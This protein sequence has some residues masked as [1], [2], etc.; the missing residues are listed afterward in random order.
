MISSRYRRSQAQAD[1]FS[2]VTAGAGKN[3]LVFIKKVELT[4]VNI[5]VPGQSFKAT[6]K[7]LIQP[8]VRVERD[9]GSRWMYER[10]MVSHGIAGRLVATMKAG[11]GTSA[12]TPSWA[13]VIQDVLVAPATSMPSAM[14][15]SASSW[16]SGSAPETP[17][18][19]DEYP[20][21][22]KAVYGQSDLLR[23]R[24][25]VGLVKDQLVGE[26]E[27]AAACR[28]SSWRR[29]AA[30]AAGQARLGHEGLPGLARFTA[31]PAVSGCRQDGAARWQMIAAYRT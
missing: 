9:T 1:R 3:S 26:I 2:G 5:D 6:K 21:L 19:P 17:V 24:N 29:G 13:V 31:R 30:P 27:K 7:R 16:P 12:R 10:W 22:L 23:P 28:Y 11:A 15:F 25:L 8:K 4:K 20:A 18:G 14:P